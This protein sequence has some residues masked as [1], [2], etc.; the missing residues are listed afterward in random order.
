M[1]SRG[2]FPA[3]EQLID[4]LPGG[5]QL[6][7]HPP[8]PEGDPF[9]RLGGGDPAAGALE[10][11]SSEFTLQPSDLVGFHAVW[12]GS[13]TIP[14]PPREPAIWARSKV[15]TTLPESEATWQPTRIFRSP[16]DAVAT[17]QA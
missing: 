6:G 5:L 2:S 9:A 14:L 10:Q 13:P 16:D 8:S 3:A 12:P 15:S 7:H 11:R 4:L 1:S 17:L